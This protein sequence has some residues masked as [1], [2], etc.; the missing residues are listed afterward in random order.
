MLTSFENVPTEAGIVPVMSA[1]CSN[2]RGDGRRARSTERAAATAV[3]R[4][5]RAAQAAR[6]AALGPGGGR[7]THRAVHDGSVTQ[8]CHACDASIGIPADEE[9]QPKSSSILVS[10]LVSQKRVG[11]QKGF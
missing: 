6:G 3:S 8:R 7:P 4:R 9:Q 1:C 5:R 2:L 10:I 11:P